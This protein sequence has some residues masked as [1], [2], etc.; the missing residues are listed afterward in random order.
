VALPEITACFGRPIRLTGN[1]LRGKLAGHPLE[2]RIRRARIQACEHVLQC[3]IR[4]KSAVGEASDH[5]ERNSKR[6]IVGRALG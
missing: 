4:R 5:E 2:I 6:T 1:R 3:L